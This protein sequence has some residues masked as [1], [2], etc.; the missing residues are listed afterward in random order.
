MKRIDPLTLNDWLN[1]N[2]KV[3]LIDVREEEEW[4]VCRLPDAELIPMHR[5]SS[6]IPFIDPS[7]PVVLYCH[8][9]I[10]SA[11]CIMYLE[12]NGPFDN[13]YNLDGGI[14]AWAK[15]VDHSMPTY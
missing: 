7:C 9:G 10:R 6:A 15:T 11:H 1:Q 5:I 4:E 8:H 13:L 2:E 14:D 12:E 3:Q